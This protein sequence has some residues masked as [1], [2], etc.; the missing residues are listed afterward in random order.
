MHTKEMVDTA[1]DSSSVVKRSQTRDPSTALAVLLFASD[2]RAG[3][4]A[5]PGWQSIW[6]FNSGGYGGRLAQ[7]PRK[8]RGHSAP[9]AVASGAAVASEV[10]VRKQWGCFQKIWCMN[11][12]RRPERWEFMVEQFL[13]LR[14]PVQRLSAVDGQTL[15]ARKLAEQGLIAP[16]ALL[17]YYLPAEQKLFGTDLTDGS[18]G[19]ALS[20]MVIWKDI[21]HM[22]DRGQASPDSMFLV[23]EDDCQ[24][25]NGFSE[26]LLLERLKHVPDDWEMIYLGGQDLMH[27]HHQYT[28]AEGVRRLY[29]G[30]RETTAYV[31]NVAGAKACLDVTIPMYWQVD[32]HLNDV[33]LREG[34]RKKEPGDTDY[35]M[36]PRGYCLWPPMVSQDRDSFKTD[37]Q[38]G[39]H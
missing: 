6:R 33:S 18:I 19:C 14:M 36:K 1:P 23:I 7:R 8:G 22:V 31:I 32:T 11:L 12:D 20:H 29:K 13:D 28:V 35:T 39:E 2:L 10:G 3:F 9:I 30:F 16:S 21:I 25:V 37:V 38:K 17:R 5:R 26:Q 4:N 34:L 27:E 24:F 15:D